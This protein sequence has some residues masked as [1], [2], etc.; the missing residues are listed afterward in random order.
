MK[1]KLLEKYKSLEPFETPDLPRLVVIT[2]KNGSGKSQLLDLLQ[3]Q[4]PTL[5]AN[6][7]SRMPSAA[8]TLKVENLEIRKVRSAP[9]GGVNPQ[10]FSAVSRSA[11]ETMDKTL[12]DNLPKFRANPKNMSTHEFRLLDKIREIRGVEA[13]D[14][15]SDHIAD[16]DYDHGDFE[17]KDIF[18]LNLSQV[19]INYFQNY[20]K[21]LSLETAS[22]REK[23]KGKIKFLNEEEFEKKYPNP[24]TTINGI[25]ETAQVD[26][27][28][29]EED[30]VEYLFK[31][32]KSY[33]PIFYNLT[34][35]A[36][37]KIQDF[38]TG[39]K[40]LMGLAFTILNSTSF[41]NA[42]LPNLL[43]LDEI[44][45][46]LH[47]SMTKQLLD[48]ID[49]NLV[50]KFGINVIMTT[51]SPS[52]IAVAPEESI[53]LLRKVGESGDRFVKVEKRVAIRNLLDGIRTFDVIPDNRK[54]IFVEARA[55][56]H[57]FNVVYESLKTSF[58][59]GVHLNFISSGVND[60]DCE[61]VK[62]TVTKLRD[63]GN[64]KIFGIIDWDLKNGNSA[65]LFVHSQG[66][67][68]SLEN[69]VLDPI[70]LGL[71]LLHEDVV[72]VS[73][74]LPGETASYFEV[75]KSKFS[76][77]KLIKLVDF[78]EQTVI[79]HRSGKKVS[80]EL[81]NGQSVQFDETYLHH[82]GHELEDLVKNTFKPLHKH[83]NPGALK[84]AITER[85]IKYFPE[86][87]PKELLSILLQI[88]EA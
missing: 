57:F 54:Q 32:N 17:V 12:I 52:T 19:I 36:E 87:L 30:P 67:R 5:D 2:G 60:G 75:F 51:H 76:A 74:I 65:G 50:K 8:K 33:E 69:V 72:K 58:K 61:L 28:L 49:I 7:K 78:V 46:S 10:S 59:S 43:L 6:T 83:T 37:V 80:V 48:V 14:L 11:I 86:F 15:T 35:K 66:K 29:K 79:T 1:I 4:D 68:Y 38:S 23:F 41:R 16:Y 21:N 71:F 88:E 42:S 85:I 44:D 31:A 63:A 62:S 20:N 18:S 64:D 3:Y 73:D 9:F 45:A 13:K 53:Y 40:V 55:D 77:D 25:L 47:P 27:R 82:Q 39:E 34:T 22:N 70:Y 26:Y 24:F 81:L 84:R 56:E